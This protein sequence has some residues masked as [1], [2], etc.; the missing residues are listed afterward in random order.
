MPR[1]FAKP[2]KTKKLNETSKS[3]LD[4]ILQ[5][6]A[7]VAQITLFIVAIFGYFITVRP[8]Y[9]KQLLDEQIAETKVSLRDAKQRLDL[10][11]TQEKKLREE[12]QKL[13]DEAGANYTVLRKNLQMKLVTSSGC[14]YKNNS[15]TIDGKKLFECIYMYVKEDIVRFLKP[16]DQQKIIKQLSIHKDEIINLPNQLEKANTKKGSRAKKRAAQLKSKIKSLEK[17]LIEAFNQFR[18]SGRDA[19]SPI[20]SLDDIKDLKN[21][22][23]VN[24]YN[25]FRDENL[26]ANLE[27]LQVESEA[28]NAESGIQFE[29]ASK[30]S[31]ILMNIYSELNR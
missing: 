10:V 28:R 24:A 1:L 21:N 27:L 15:I 3:R 12:Y 23:E 11:Q 20:N 14:V 31:A 30:L 17:N 7:W 25:K 18:S 4:T 26:D 8:V 29:L 13:N 6:T 9:Q 19:G 22:E 16:E 2:K 5:R